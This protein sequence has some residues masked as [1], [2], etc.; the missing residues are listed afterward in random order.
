MSYNELSL[1][2]TLTETDIG[3]FFSKKKEEI[4][5]TREERHLVESQMRSKKN[6]GLNFFYENYYNPDDVYVRIVIK[7]DHVS[8]RYTRFYW[9]YLRVFA[10]LG[11]LMQSMTMVFY[12]IYYLLDK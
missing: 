9:N 8:V 12:V 10:V 6:I 3:R 11:G 4:A 7:T 1:K 5:Y 2:Q